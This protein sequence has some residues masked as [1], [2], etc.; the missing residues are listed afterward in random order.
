MVVLTVAL[1]SGVALLLLLDVNSAKRYA[2]ARLT[3]RSSLNACDWMSVF[4]GTLKIA[5]INRERSWGWVGGRVAELDTTWETVLVGE[6]TWLVG[7]WVDNKR[8]DV[9]RGVSFM[10]CAAVSATLLK[11]MV[12]LNVDDFWTLDWDTFALWVT[13]LVL[14]LSEED[15][16]AG[17][18]V[19]ELTG[20][21]VVLMKT[22]DEL[23]L[24]FTVTFTETAVE[25][26]WGD[27][28]LVALTSR[29][30]C[31]TAELVFSDKDGDNWM[32]VALA[33]WVNAENPG[34]ELALTETV[35]DMLTGSVDTKLGCTILVV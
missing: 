27:C 5:S 16:K 35:D 30:V 11:K 32:D 24:G 25:T 1:I 17:R 22:L 9:G 8:V 33:E 12:E 7:I 21:M 29:V 19:V 14:A 2:S 28:E 18:E 20:G 15:V 4:W 31:T 3:S 13:S 34:V 6:T 26:T 10:L 23:P